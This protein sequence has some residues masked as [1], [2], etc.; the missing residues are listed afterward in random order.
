MLIECKEG[1][2]M[3]VLKEK[4]KKDDLFQIF[5]PSKTYNECIKNWGVKWDAEKKEILEETDEK[6]RMKFNT[7]YGPPY[8]F[9]N[10]LS[11]DYLNCKFELNYCELYN[12]FYGTIRYDE[13]GMNEKE[14]KLTYEILEGK[15]EKHKMGYDNNWMKFKIENRKYDEKFQMFYDE[16]YFENFY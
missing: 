7:A 5:Y 15:K 11:N 12:K 8:K 1:K 6:L 9:V 16:N 14:E 13:N 10:K 2:T 4:M 3:D